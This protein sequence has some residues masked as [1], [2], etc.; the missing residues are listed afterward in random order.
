MLGAFKQ[1]RLQP[2]EPIL[3]RSF[4]K[5]LMIF[6]FKQDLFSYFCYEF[7]CHPLASTSVVYWVY[8]VYSFTSILGHIPLGH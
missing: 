7:I 8:P 5:I 6:A 4:L 1:D 2:I 3:L